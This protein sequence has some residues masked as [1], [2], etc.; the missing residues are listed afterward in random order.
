MK[1]CLVTAFPPSRGGL[2]EYGFHVA[3]ELQQNPL[4]S[5][6][7]LA[8]TVPDAQDDADG[9]NVVRCWTFNDRNSASKVLDTIR[10]IDPDVV[11]FNLLFTT[12]GHKPMAAFRGLTL[13][14]LTRLAGYYT[15]VTLHHLMDFIDLEGAGVRFPLFYRAAGNIATKML[16][17]ANSVSVLMPAYRTTLQQKYGRGNVQ[18]RSHGILAR[19]P[20]F[21]DFS[22]RNNP[23]QRVLAF[24][25]WGTY[26]RL[27]PLI[28]AFQSIATDFPNTK[29]VIAGGDHPRTQGYVASLAQRYEGPRIEF[30]GYVPEERIGE[31]FRSASI[32]V[33]PYS[34]ATGASGVAHLACAYGVPIVSSHVPDFEHMA[35]EEG[36]AI[37]F[38]E[39]GKT[40][41]LA[42]KLGRLLASP[43]RQKAMALQN[44]SAALGMTMP[45]TIRE[46]IR[47]FGRAQ[48]T[49]A[50]MPFRRFRR[51]PPWISRS[52]IGRFV[53]RGLLKSDQ[54]FGRRR[55]Q[56]RI[57]GVPLFNSNGHSGR[58]L[59][60]STH[61][62]DGNGVTG[63]GPELTSARTT[64][65]TEKNN[66][67]DNHRERK[68]PEEAL[69]YWPVD[70]QDGNGSQREHAGG[71]QV[72]LRPLR[73]E[74][75]GNGNGR[76]N[77]GGGRL[78]GLGVY[79]IGGEQTIH[80]DGQARAG[81]IDGE[82]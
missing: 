13:P 78:S 34:S 14:P 28:D 19:S 16:L 56:P 45:S 27:E 15:H 31:L 23:Q 55:P 3:Q 18:F 67:P 2:S 70:A 77:E 25:K 48:H 17:L 10:E 26:K 30:T 73:V 44:F 29:L 75:G 35:Q 59:V 53:L 72:H 50:L 37:D 74:G 7:V 52:F 82:V 71:E 32:T 12:F 65:R 66:A 60:A 81:E 54:L 62:H 51:L 80:A 38:Y 40:Q 5:L 20:E 36:M 9:L 39:T 4:L 57:G 68:S 24:G 41:D 58:H 1:I 47:H 76:H 43:E 6:T 46:Y 22:L 79:R 42:E 49:R 64:T 8:D 33:M 21:P 63:A 61:A 11:W 69:A